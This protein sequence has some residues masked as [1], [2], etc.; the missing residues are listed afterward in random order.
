MTAGAG[1]S[2]ALGV[3][4]CTL[5]LPSLAIWAKMGVAALT[6]LIGS[7]GA[8]LNL[9]ARL[10]SPWL[11]G[12]FAVFFVLFALAMFGVFE[13][14]L[15]EFVREPLERL[16]RRAHGGSL[17]GATAMGALSTLVVSPCIS[18]PLAGALVYISSTGDTLGGG[19]NL[20]ALGLG[21]GT[22]LLL[23]TLFGK[24]LLPGSGPAQGVFF[25]ED[26]HLFATTIRDNLLVARGDATDTEL[27]DAL[28]RSGL[29][30]WLDGLPDGLDTVLVGGASAVSAGQRRRL[31]LARALITTAPAVLLDEPTEHLDSSDA[32]QILVDLLTP[33][34]LFGSD[35][36][37]VVATHHLGKDVGCQTV[38]LA[39]ER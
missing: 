16:N 20:F 9:Q 38:D 18:A 28:V 14:R 2:A 4:L 1:Q 13:L 25:A 22:P 23:I 29:G 10:Q 34:A 11:L 32:E 8:A 21:M 15:P 27:R 17:P 36:T 19:I 5:F 33:G 26:A 30:P 31:L 6:A 37:V 39:P 12:T 3:L 24:S 7:F 35:R